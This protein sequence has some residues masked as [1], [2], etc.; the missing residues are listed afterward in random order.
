MWMPEASGS[1][2]LGDVDSGTSSRSGKRQTVI[3]PSLAA[4]IPEGLALPHRSYSSNAF[5]ICHC[6][7]KAKYLGLRRQIK[8]LRL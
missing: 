8:K 3:H 7:H 4:A 5:P 2:K 1:S 6:L